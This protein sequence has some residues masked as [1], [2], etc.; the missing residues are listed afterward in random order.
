VSCPKPTFRETQPRFVAIADS[1]R[2]HGLILPAPGVTLMPNPAIAAL[3]CY[4][5]R[6]TAINAYP[7]LRSRPPKPLSIRLTS[8][9]R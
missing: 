8:Y 6:D 4:A 3:I 5:P 2:E 1:I 9:V 7:V